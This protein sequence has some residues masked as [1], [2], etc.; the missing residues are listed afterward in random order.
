MLSLLIGSFYFIKIWELERNN[1]HFWLAC[2]F[3]T[4]AALIKLPAVVFL[5][6]FAVIIYK[7]QRRKSLRQPGDYA[8]FVVTIAIVACWYL[9]SS[10][11]VREYGL[12]YFYLG[13]DLHQNL[14][15]LLDWRFWRVALISRIPEIVTNYAIFPF[16]VT[17]IVLYRKI[18]IPVS[19]AA[20]VVLLGLYYAVGGYHLYVHDYYSLPAVPVVALIAGGGAWFVL[21]NPVRTARAAAILLLIIAPIVTLFRVAPWYKMNFPAFPLAR[22]LGERY[23]PKGSLMVAA[24]RVDP[25]LLF[26]TFRNGWAM[27]P[28][29][30][31]ERELNKMGA[32]FLITTAY[33]DSLIPDHETLRLVAQESSLRLYQIELQDTANSIGVGVPGQ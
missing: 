22:G 10:F 4:L 16:L 28:Q 17:G 30:V 9:Y 31:D 3:F 18:G 15:F 2:L 14:S 5:P 21:R 6:F 11:L 19:V 8:F 12:K 26:F 20:L 33:A 24:W 29:N 27:P 32:R 23:V 7:S 13:G 1:A 25:T